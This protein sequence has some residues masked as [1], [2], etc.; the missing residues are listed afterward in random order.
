LFGT[1][2][3]TD[4]K[5]HGIVIA[6]GASDQASFVTGAVIAADGGRTAI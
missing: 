1:E 4:G 2:T 3:G 5:S 6:F